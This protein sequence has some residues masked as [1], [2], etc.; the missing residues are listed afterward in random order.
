MLLLLSKICGGPARNPQTSRSMLRFLV[1]LF[2]PALR[3]S[4]KSGR[5]ACS[6]RDLKSSVIADRDLKLIGF[7]GTFQ[8][9]LRPVL[10][11]RVC[12]CGHHS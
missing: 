9:V 6:N 7:E 4:A 11:R 3:V 8:L 5:D 10:P 2:Q 12:N 1:P